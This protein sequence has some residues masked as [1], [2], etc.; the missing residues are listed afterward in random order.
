[1]ASPGATKDRFVHNFV[2][3]T[4]RVSADN[5]V[6]GQAPNNI[7]SY[8]W[9]WYRPEGDR[10]KWKASTSYGVGAEVQPL[11]FNGHKYTVT[12]AGTTGSTQ[13]TWPTTAG[14]TVVD[15]S[16]TWKENGV[17]DYATCGG[18][19]RS[20]PFPISDVQGV[21]DATS[22]AVTAGGTTQKWR[23][24]DA[25]KQLNQLVTY[26]ING[27]YIE[28][29]G[30]TGLTSGTTGV[31][32]GNDQFNRGLYAAQACA[33]YTAANPATPFYFIPQPDLSGSGSGS[34]TT[35]HVTWFIQNFW[36][37]R[38][39]WRSVNI[40]G[41]TTY[42][43]SP[44]GFENKTV[45]FYNTVKSNLATAGIPIA[46]DAT[47]VSLS[48]LST[49]SSILYGY[50]NWGSRSPGNNAYSSTNADGAH[51]AG[52]TWTHPVSFQDCR[53]RSNVYDEAL[54]SLTLRT[55]LSNAIQ[56]GADK[57]LLPTLDDE[58]EGSGFAP[59]TSHGYVPLELFSRL[60]TKFTSGASP[61][62]DGWWSI[63]HRKH[64]AAAT[65]TWQGYSLGSGV[66]ANLQTLRGGASPAADIIE[67][68]SMFPKAATVVV[69]LTNGS[70]YTRTVTLNVP[71]GD[72]RT[73]VNWTSADVAA[74]DITI[75]AVASYGGSSTP[76]LFVPDRAS[77]TDTTLPIKVSAS[78][79]VQDMTYYAASAVASLPWSGTVTA[80]AVQKWDTD[81][82]LGGS[83]RLTNVAAAV[84]TTDVPTLGQVQGLVSGNSLASLYTQLGG[85][86]NGEPTILPRKIASNSGM[87]TSS[88]VMILTGFNAWK[89][90]SITQ[91][92]LFS[93]GTAAGATPTLVRAGIY[94]VAADGSITLVASIASDTTL[95]AASS[96]G[97]T[98]ALTAA[99]SKTAGQR[100]ALGILVVSTAA[101]P[102][103]PGVSMGIGPITTA[104]PWESGQVSG[105]TDLPAS[106]TYAQITTS[107]NNRQIYAELL[108]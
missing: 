44:Y 36:A 31:D 105:L 43:V 3:G 84:N 85:L 74:G 103:L 47:F 28:G 67:I 64:L 24:D 38:A 16:V 19:T 23:L 26:G 40:G 18:R 34:I 82:D 101:M 108:P 61:T 80:R 45:A 76:A 104:L 41:V 71:A 93:G 4:P 10:R 2:F 37:Y 102:T 98:R 11:T 9:E 57:L 14:A 52:Q 79:L 60:V 46:W 21:G 56:M 70:G 100:Y 97:Y 12:V 7:D 48:S 75:S 68:S 1:M 30:I 27:Y 91:L 99:L 32:A 33:T 73:T 20:L 53:P 54:G 107:S 22:V 8:R 25:T 69:T 65:P 58:T 81:F 13:P 66:A 15:G 17:P 92:K 90:E 49:Y 6:A 55:T 29:L 62:L 94:S 87:T 83:S 88:G 63:W 95:L 89:T 72:Q 96:T 86:T 50:G 106:A 42:L 5:G 51:A 39:A 35:N 59:N 78:P 77:L